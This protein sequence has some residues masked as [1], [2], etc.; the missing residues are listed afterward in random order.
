[1]G[2]TDEFYVTVYYGGENYEGYTY[3]NRHK[4][5]LPEKYGGDITYGMSVFKMMD[6]LNLMSKSGWELVQ[7]YTTQYKTL[8]DGENYICHYILKRSNSI[9]K[10]E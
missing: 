9:D 6:G 1:M 3:F 8:E 10:K 5:K 4:S 2:T 7:E